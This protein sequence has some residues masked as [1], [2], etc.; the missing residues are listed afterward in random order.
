VNYLV[1]LGWDQPTGPEE[2]GFYEWWQIVGLIF[3]LFV[4][5]C[6]A[7]LT[8]RPWLGSAAMSVTMAAAFAFDASTDPESDGLWPVGAVLVLIAMG[9][10]TP[11]I[12][13]VTEELLVRLS[14]RPRRPPRR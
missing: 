4:I 5:T 11:V 2:P 6:C 10:F 9:S 14:A 1:W 13:R 7:G 3:F 8:R 12:A